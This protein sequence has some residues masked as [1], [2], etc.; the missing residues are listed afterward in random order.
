MLSLSF[1]ETWSRDR[2]R[3][4]VAKWIQQQRDGKPKNYYDRFDDP[5]EKIADRIVGNYQP[6]TAAGVVRDWA[7]LALLPPVV[8]FVLGALM[9]WALR[10][11]RRDINAT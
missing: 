7:S 8:L 10:G 4:A 11:F 6:R 3:L 1:R 5:A 2:S 9:L